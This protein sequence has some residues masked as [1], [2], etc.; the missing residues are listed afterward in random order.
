MLDTVAA[1]RMAQGSPA[2]PASE[3]RAVMAHY[4]TGVVVVTAMADGAPVGFVV[5]SFTSISLDP[6]LVGFFADQSSTTYPKVERAGAFCANVLSSDHSHPVSYTHLQHTVLECELGGRWDP[7]AGRG[8]NR[9]LTAA[10]RGGH[11][12]RERGSQLGGH[13]R[14]SLC[15]RAVLRRV[16]R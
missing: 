4:P 1:P 10:P 8:G 12:V 15:R 16:V 2:V 3:L 11:P 6:P 7:M 5:G 9:R 13:R 14:C